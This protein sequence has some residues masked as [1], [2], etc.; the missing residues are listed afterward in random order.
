MVWIKKSFYSI[1][2]TFVCFTQS[3]A[4]I[5]FSTNPAYSAIKKQ[6]GIKIPEDKHFMIEAKIHVLGWSKNNLFAYII[7]KANE[8]KDFE[9]ATL[10]IQNIVTDK[11][12]ARFS[13]TFNNNFQKA[14]QKK[15]QIIKSY[16]RKFNIDSQNFT[17]NPYKQSVVK[18]FPIYY[19][20][21]KIFVKKILHYHLLYQNRFV[22]NFLLLMKKVN[23]N[24]VFKKT[25]FKHRYNIY[26]S[27]FN[28][29][30][31]GYISSPYTD[32]IAL[33]LAKVYRGWEGPPHVI[34]YIIVGASLSKAFKKVQ[35]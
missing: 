9:E 7:H 5:D 30:T 35:K 20:G 31:L 18:Q 24:G 19:N 8:A 29:Y 28:I 34:S 2:L 14:I 25:I 22:T 4:I 26:D 10:F 13:W 3:F 11:I 16:L 17:I 6:Y 12:V 15:S 1:L 33:I 32:R 21:S 23:K 27:I